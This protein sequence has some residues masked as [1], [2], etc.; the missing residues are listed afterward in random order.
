M[1]ALLEVLVDAIGL[2][3]QEGDVL[4][5]GLDEAGEDVDGLGEALGELVVVL[6]APGVAEAGELALEDGKRLAA[7]FVQVL[8]ALGK[9]A[10]LGGIDDGP[11]HADLRL[12]LPQS[13]PAHD[14][15]PRTRRIVILLVTPA[16][17][18]PQ[19]I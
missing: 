16:P 6:V 2:A 1:S 19:K 4:L 17:A 15:L 11:G 5:R 18:S 12:F 13:G 7:L 3:E 14:A 8:E 10:Q 9:A